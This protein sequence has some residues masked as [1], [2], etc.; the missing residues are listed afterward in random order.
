MDG[1]QPGPAVDLAAGG[2]RGLKGQPVVFADVPAVA[3]PAHPPLRTQSYRR[4]TE[5]E[6]FKTN[7]EKKYKKKHGRI[8]IIFCIS[9]PDQDLDTVTELKYLCIFWELCKVI[10]II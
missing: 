4:N 10:L 1:S 8:R 9:N 7:I 6:I 3:V 2:L 5:K